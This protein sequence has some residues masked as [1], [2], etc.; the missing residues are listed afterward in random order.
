MTKPTLPGD[1]ARR[2]P[3]PPRLLRQCWTLL[4]LAAFFPAPAH[5]GLEILVPA[6]FYPVPGSPWNQLIAD[7]PRVPITAILNPGSGPGTFQDLTYVSTVNA[8]RAAGGRILAY[9]PT[10]YGARPAA[11]IKADVDTYRAWYAID[12]VFLDETPSDNLPAH[13]D[14]YAD[15]YQFIKGRN[16][17][18]RVVMNPGTNAAEE[19]LSRPCAD[20]LVL[21]ENGTGYDSY[22]TDGYVY[23]YGRDRVAHLLYDVAGA[24]AMNARVDQALSRNVGLLFITD[25]VLVPN[26]WDTLPAYW[27]AEVNRV[28]ALNVSA[29]PEV[30]PDVTLRVA[31]TPD[32]RALE[33]SLAADR[34]DGVTAALFD[35]RGR[36]LRAW[37]P[38]G[39]LAAGRTVRLPL[40][41][42]AGGPPPGGIYFLRVTGA[43]FAATRRLVLPG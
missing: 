37:P 42:A 4:V 2:R 15:I 28:I 27:A 43:G 19:Y 38:T 11:A 8:F 14:Y 16:A 3:R 26:P 32:G 30:P 31:P 25:D 7:A 33:L 24:A 5:A 23:R 36:R 1:F 18:Y 39:P 22:H 13:L 29:V 17:G 20:A 21:Y 6:Y 34:P 9:V 41:G 12:G 10:T 40:A 35:V